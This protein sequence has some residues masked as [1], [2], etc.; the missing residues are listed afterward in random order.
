MKA[1]LPWMGLAAVLLAGCDGSG[2][3][4]LDNVQADIEAK[5]H[6]QVV[7]HGVEAQEALQAYVAQK[8]ENPPSIEALEA[9]TGKLKSLPPGKKYSYDPVAGKIDVVDA[10]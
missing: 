8:G 2:A 10:Q 4:P 9:L 1:K 5:K 6:A 7:V 3:N